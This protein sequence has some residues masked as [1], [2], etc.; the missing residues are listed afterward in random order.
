M[1][2]NFWAKTIQVRSKLVLKVPNITKNKSFK[3]KSK[4]KT[5]S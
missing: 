4:I 2:V 5:I 1:T 3:N